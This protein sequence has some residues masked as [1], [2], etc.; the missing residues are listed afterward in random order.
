MGSLCP[1][2]VACNHPYYHH[3]LI[4]TTARFWPPGELDDVVEVRL[5]V[6][7]PPFRFPGWPNLAVA[8]CTCSFSHSCESSG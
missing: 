7:E 6:G 5:K 8:T 1:Y 3:D 4:V 2:S